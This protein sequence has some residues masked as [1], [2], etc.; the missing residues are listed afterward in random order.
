MAIAPF[1]ASDITV[2]DICRLTSLSPF[3]ILPEPRIED[4]ALMT[5]FI[6]AAAAGLM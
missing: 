3:F 5:S 2:E 4:D 6:R 1:D